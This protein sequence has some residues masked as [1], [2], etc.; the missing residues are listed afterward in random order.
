MNKEIAFFNRLKNLSPIS[1]TGL[2]TK[3]PSKATIQKLTESFVNSL[4][5]DFPS[6]TYT[7]FNTSNKLEESNPGGQK[8]LLCQVST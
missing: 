3:L 4:Q 2:T 7:I 1:R 5:K 8:C 6:T